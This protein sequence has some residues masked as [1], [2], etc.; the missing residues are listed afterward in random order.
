MGSK[1][2]SGAILGVLV[3]FSVPHVWFAVQTRALK[4]ELIIL[5]PKLQR[6]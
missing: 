2:C 3:T 4:D 5:E 6:K 1:V